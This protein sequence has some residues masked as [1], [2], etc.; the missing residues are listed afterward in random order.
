MPDRIISLMLLCGPDYPAVP[1]RVKFQTKL[2][3][4]F[5]VH[6]TP[7]AAAAAIAAGH[8]SFEHSPKPRLSPRAGVGPAPLRPPCRPRAPPPPTRVGAPRAGAL[9]RLAP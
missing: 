8:P 5:V 1:P 2:N 7:L 6:Y 4:P 3:F 9:G